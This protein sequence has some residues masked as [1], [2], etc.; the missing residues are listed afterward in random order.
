MK[1]HICDFCHSMCKPN[2]CVIPDKVEGKMF[3]N[4]IEMCDK[5]ARELAEVTAPKLLMMHF[6][7]LEEIK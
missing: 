6:K 4:K 7:P 1:V 3:Y 5:C 2:F